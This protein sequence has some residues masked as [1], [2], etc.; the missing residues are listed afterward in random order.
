MEQT[1]IEKEFDIQVKHILEKIKLILVKKAKEY[2][3][4]NNPF[5]NFEEGAKISGQTPERV[6]NGFLLK[7]LISYQ[8]ILNDLD[9]GIFP[10]QEMIDE[11]FTD[12]LVYFTI[13]NIM[14]S[15]RIKKEL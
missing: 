2:R 11:K 8:D 15:E 1:L 5:H 4:N 14:L 10:K 7:H 13:Q 9:K 6:L 3:R 12:I